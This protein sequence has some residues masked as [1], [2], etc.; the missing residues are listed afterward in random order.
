VRDRILVR[1]TKDR[2]A[3]VLRFTPAARHQFAEQLKAAERTSR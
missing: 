3:R 2:T 1:D